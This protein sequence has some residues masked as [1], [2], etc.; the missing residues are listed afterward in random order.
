V[1]SRDLQ[2]KNCKKSWDDTKI[3]KLHFIHD[4]AQQGILTFV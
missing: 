3:R 1:A 4:L 2:R